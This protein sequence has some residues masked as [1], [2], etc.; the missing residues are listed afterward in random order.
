MSHQTTITGM[1]RQVRK[2]TEEWARDAKNLKALQIS[3]MGRNR[4]EGLGSGHCLWACSTPSGTIGIGWRWTEILPGVLAIDDPLDVFSN[5]ILLGEAGLPV[6]D[7]RRVGH[8]HNAIHDLDW[9]SV[10][11]QRLAGTSSRP[12]RVRQPRA[13]LA[14]R[15]ASPSCV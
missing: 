10:V 12:G 14:R 8:L 2:P 4:S 1:W 7:N 15:P 11:R 3:C 9:Q 6:D 5:V 13:T